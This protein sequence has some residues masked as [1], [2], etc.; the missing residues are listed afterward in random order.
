[1]TFNYGFHVPDLKPLYGI[2]FE[3]DG[4]VINVSPSEGY[5]L[6]NVKNLWP[7]ALAITRLY[8]L[9]PTE[10]AKRNLRYQRGKGGYWAKIHDELLG[11]EEELV[12]KAKGGSGKDLKK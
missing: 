2:Q 9:E 11:E 7:L 10:M 12:E 8:R 4:E 6:Q 1:V 3:R 5:D